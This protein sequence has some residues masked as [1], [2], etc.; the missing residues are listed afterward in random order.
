MKHIQ[1]RERE[2]RGQPLGFIC[3]VLNWSI[4]QCVHYWALKQRPWWQA[5]RASTS[6]A[7]ASGLK[8]R[9]G[10]C[11][12]VCTQTGRF[13]HVSNEKHWKAFDVCCYVRSH[14]DLLPLQVDSCPA[15]YHSL[16]CISATHTHTGTHCS[17]VAT[18]LTAL[19]LYRSLQIRFHSCHDTLQAIELK[20]GLTQ[21]DSL[22][23]ASGWKLLTNEVA[24]V[25]WANRS[26]MGHQHFAINKLTRIPS[27]CNF[28][29]YIIIHTCMHALYSIV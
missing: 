21:P 28:S 22:R 16:S 27:H 13:W 3:T 14:A 8:R 25:A 9:V 7:T 15:S 6:P 26:W 20:D 24:R 5:A 10:F 19:L 12:L 1:Q 2:R 29:G 17:I 23:K 4:C 18:V 11:D